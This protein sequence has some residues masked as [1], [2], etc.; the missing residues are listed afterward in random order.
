MG[1]GGGG[2][3]SQGV[4]RPGLETD[5]LSPVIAGAKK[6]LIYTSIHPPP[7]FPYI[8]TVQ[9]LAE[10]KVSFAFLVLL[11]AMLLYKSQTNGGKNAFCYH[12]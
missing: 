2:S 11:L 7:L 1:T 3:L 6:T 4:K 9:C 5:H 8:F 12:D 10:H